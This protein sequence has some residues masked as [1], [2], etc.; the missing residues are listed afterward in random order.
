VVGQNWKEA[1]MNKTNRILIILVLLVIMALC[2]VTLVFPVRTL[3]SAARQLSG[4]AASIARL[5]VPFRDSG[6]F[7]RAAV[8]ALFAVTLDIICVLLIIAEFRWPTPRFI[9]AEKTTGGEVRVSIASI[10][11]R[12]KYEVDQLSSVLRCK[13]KVSA[14]RG[15]V[16]LELD[17]E[18][19]AGIDVPA[20]AEQIVETVR[21]VIEEGMGLKLARPPKVNLRTVPYPRTPIMPA[22]P[23][24]TIPAEP[25]ET[26]PA[27]QEP[28]FTL[29]EP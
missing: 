8:G 4:L 1:T 24:E 11:D 16:V 28:P 22:R 13:P 2:T 19:A 25:P 15:G 26:I 17:V 10:A 20:K 14:R 12:L 9:R 21:A 18:A 23:G 3:T 5:G 29:P 27:E 7:V 6:W